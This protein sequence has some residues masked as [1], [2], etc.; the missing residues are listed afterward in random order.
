MDIIMALIGLAT[1]YQ[2]ITQP[3]ILHIWYFMAADS[4]FV[5]FIPFACCSPFNSHLLTFHL[6]IFEY[7]AF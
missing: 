1:I 5:I 2:L 3:I 4:S 6:N 7:K